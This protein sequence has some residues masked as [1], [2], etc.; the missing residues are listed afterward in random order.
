MFG[1]RSSADRPRPSAQALSSTLDWMMAKTCEE[2]WLEAFEVQR[3][4][5]IM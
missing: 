2:T 5:C 4:V 3:V 1:S